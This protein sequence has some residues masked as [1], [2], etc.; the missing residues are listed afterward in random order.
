MK[1]NLILI[2]IFLSSCSDITSNKERDIDL[3]NSY[4]EISGFLD[5]IVIENIDKSAKDE[6]SKSFK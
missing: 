1:N 4:K 6:F 3:G 2:L 5:Q